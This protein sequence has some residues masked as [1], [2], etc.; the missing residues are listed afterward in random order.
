[1]AATIIAAVD[2]SPAAMQA[3]AIC[4]REKAPVGTVV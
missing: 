2:K 4:A 3:V 1:M